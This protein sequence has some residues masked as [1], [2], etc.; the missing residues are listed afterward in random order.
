MSRMMYLIGLGAVVAALVVMFPIS[1]FAAVPHQMT[2]QGKL[3]NYT[4]I[5]I[6]GTHNITFVIFGSEMGT[7]SLWAENHPSVDVQHGLFSV[8]LGE[9]APLNLP[10]DVPYYLEIRV[11][12]TT[13]SPRAKLTTS[14]YAM[15][16]E[17]I[18]WDTLSSFM[19]GVPD[20]IRKGPSNFDAVLTLVDTTYT[21][22]GIGLKVDS[23]G[24][25][26]IRVDNSSKEGISI[27]NS[28]RHGLSISNTGDRGILIA[29]PHNVGIDI[30]AD[31]TTLYGLYIHKSAGISA[32]APDTGIVVRDACVS[33]YFDGDV[34]IDGKLSVSL[35]KLDTLRSVNGADGDTIWTMAQF[36]VNGELI[37]DSIQAA[38]DTLYVDDNTSID[39]NLLVSDSVGIGIAAPGYKL[40]V[41][42]STGDYNAVGYFVNHC[43][44]DDGYG[45]YAQASDSDF[46]GYGVYGVGGYVGVEGDVYPTGTEAYYGL[47]GY[48]GGSDGRN[49]GVYGQAEGDSINYGIYGRAEDNGTGAKRNIAIFGYASGADTNWAGYFDEGNVDIENDLYLD[50]G[51]N[52]GTGFGTNGQYLM[53]DGTDAVW[54]YLSGSL[55][56]VD[57]LRSVNGA[58]SDTI[59]TMAQFYVNGELIVDS[60]QAV[61]GLISL[62][63]SVSID[64]NLNVVDSLTVGDDANISGDATIAGDAFITDSC[65]VGTD[66]LVG[67]DLSV[68]NNASI[69]GTATVGG[70]LTINS[71]LNDGTGLGANGQYLMTDG[72]DAVWSYLSGSLINVDTLRSVNGADG[73]TIWTMAQFYVNGELIVDSIQAVGGLISL[74]DSVSIDG[75]LNVVDSLTVGDDANISGD[76]T[77]AGDAFITDSCSV[78]TDLLVGNDLS[79]TNNASITGTAT[80]GGDLTINSGL[81]DGTGLGANGQ[82]LMTDGADAVWS[83]LSGSLI[84]VDTLRSV[85]GADGDTIWTMAQFYVNGELIVDSIQAVGDTVFVDDNL[86]VNDS[87]IVSGD[88]YVNGDV[89]IGTNSPSQELQVI[90]DVITGGG[91]TNN[92]GTDEFIEIQAQSENW[93]IGVRN[94]ATPANSDFHIGLTQAEDG[95]FHI[96]PDGNIGIGTTSP[97]AKLH[98][99]GN[100][101][102]DN[103]N[104]YYGVDATQADS[105]WIYD[106]GDTTRFDADNPIKVGHASLVVE[107]DGDVFVSQ[108]LYADT[109]FARFDFDSV[110]DFTWDTLNSYPDTTITN[111]IRDSLGAYPDTTIFIAGQ[112]T[113]GANATTDT[114]IISNIIPTTPIIA[115]V[116]TN[117]ISNAYTISVYATAGTLFIYRA[118]ADTAKSDIY[119]YSGMR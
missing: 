64:G 70:D 88:A 89:G 111:A 99:N 18:N 109:V 51:L 68:T 105:F 65:S 17:N 90:G 33:A 61:G 46:Y 86:K 54:S 74:D 21:D 59:W 37:T 41:V 60:I 82:Y 78:G 22:Y 57:T 62:D 98:I 25:T 16:A 11:D 28:G 79:V 10:F 106:D 101:F 103:G 29:N 69:T 31:S 36:Y 110:Y 119:N 87:L 39:G 1:A 75:N 40:H 27:L 56:N 2:Y 26:G 38:G 15:Y 20:T 53:T 104:R 96:Q 83:Y 72:A 84:N 50:G 42:D 92:D 95:I 47:Y 91:A 81:N 19:T 4:G 114:V 9:T 43:N 116:F 80:V 107:T 12:G 52:D 23:A 102:V 5:A 45:I 93:Y 55:I 117:T 58:D 44:G 48:V 35:V 85:S 71:G 113:F 8:I 73:D 108:N 7:D 6:N 14:P 13:L 76:A 63:D 66:L 112:D 3:T 67:N 24:F 77:I 94:L 100:V 97:L 118:E 30:A 34:T 49:F 32:C 115:S